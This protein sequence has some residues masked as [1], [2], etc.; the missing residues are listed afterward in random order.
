M[1][2]LFELDFGPSEPAP[3]SSFELFGPDENIQKLNN[4]M[5]KMNIDKQQEEN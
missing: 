2:D 5:N 3:K 4:I 1:P